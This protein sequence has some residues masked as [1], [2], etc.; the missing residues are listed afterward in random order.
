MPVPVLVGGDRPTSTVDA[1]E[2]AGVTAYCWEVA[3]CPAAGM[4]VLVAKTGRLTR[5]GRQVP[6]SE[7]AQASPDRSERL[8][9]HPGCAGIQFEDVDLDPLDLGPAAVSHAGRADS[10][11]TDAL[12][13]LRL[14]EAEMPEELRGGRGFSFLA[15]RGFSGR[16]S[17]ATRTAVFS[18]VTKE[19]R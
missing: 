4:L 10:G 3:Q 13:T 19:S 14:G 7:A 11:P 9:V 17:S 5:A 16:R 2:A 15:R 18:S 12:L 8:Q 1:L 6:G